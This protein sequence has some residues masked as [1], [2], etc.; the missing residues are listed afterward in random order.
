MRL[1]GPSDKPLRFNGREAIASAL[2][3]R[4]HAMSEAGEKLDVITFAGNGEPTMH[5]H[6]A[7]IVDDTVALRDRFFLRQG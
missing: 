3:A 6:F 5:P 4:L 2:E 7:E 1:D